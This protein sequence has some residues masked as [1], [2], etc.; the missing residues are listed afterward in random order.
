LNALSEWLRSRYNLNET[1]A[2]EVL[3]KTSGLSASRNGLDSESIAHE[4]Q[5]GRNAGIT[6]L[7]AGIALVELEGIHQP[8]HEQI[9]ADLDAC[10]DA[11]GLVLSWDLWHI[12]HRYIS[13]IGSFVTK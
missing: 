9:Q 6:N 7:F 1:E 10:R 3:G 5:R 2:A 4:I 12:P 11:D 13:A 8:T